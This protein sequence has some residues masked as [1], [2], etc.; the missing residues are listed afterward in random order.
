VTRS[1]RGYRTFVPA[2]VEGEIVLQDAPQAPQEIQRIQAAP[3]TETTKTTGLR[4]LEKGVATPIT[5]AQAFVIRSRA[6]SLMTGGA[7]TAIWFMVRWALPL[8]TGASTAGVFVVGA[9]SIAA[10]LV[11]F[12]C[13]WFAA[14]A[15][16]MATS[17]G[18]ADLFESY[19][20]QRRIDRQS[21]AMVDAYR[22]ANGVDK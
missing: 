14:Y 21:D 16:D 20:T 19:R 2:T 18:G 6:I 10:G 11:A 7:I 8:T 1:H 3:L 17:P 15:V 13:V 4:Q 12:L 22:K 9:F 5:R